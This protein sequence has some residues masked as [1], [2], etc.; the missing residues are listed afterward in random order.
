MKT[1]CYARYSS[2]L[3]RETSLEDQISEAARYATERGWGVN[4]GHIYTD[5]GVSGASIEGR[6]GLQALLTASASTPRPFDVVLVD[7][8][9]RIA[10]DLADALRTMQTLKFRGVRVIYISQGIDSASEQADALVTMH[11]LVDQLYLREMAKKIKRGLAGQFERGFV[12]GGKTYGYRTIGVPSGTINV[13]GNPELVGKRRV[14]HD[15]EADVVRRIFE[16]TARGIGVFTIIR[17]LQDRIPGPW[18]KPWTQGTIRRILRNEVYLGKLIW[19][20][21]SFERQPG[22]NK[23]V[24]RPQPRAQW[25]VAE[26][27]NLRIISDT[28]WQQVRAR[29][30]ET[31]ARLKDGHL[32]RGGLPGSRSKHLL[33]GFL[34]CG[35]CG[36]SVGVVSS[37]K[38]A[39][40]R[41]GCVRACR[42]Y[43]C[44]NRIETKVERL[45]VR[46]LDRLQAELVKP[47]IADY[48]VRETIRRGH[49]QPS[50]RAKPETLTAE[51]DRERQKLQNLVRALEDGEPSATIVQAIRTREERIRTLEGERA[52]MLAPVP[53]VVLE[54][55]RVRQELA[56]LAGLLRES[57]ERARPVFRQLQLQVT[58]FPIEAAGE[59]P[60]LK[61][62]ATCTLDALTT[63]FPIMRRSLE[64]A[65]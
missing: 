41:Y 33:S 36:G 59:R 5:A 53:P 10:R 6:P 18:G 17:R 14:L 56:N 16:W 23:K 37:G 7:D 45:E 8:S 27:P 25:K 2:D 38:A 13:D 44:Q 65:A 20:R 57:V 42:Q 12:T 32:A 55:E 43:T 63:E 58:L 52:R 28:L 22:T 15:A 60:H 50:G 51:I 3:Q 4:P 35:E 46:V 30:H 54:P 49:Q 62:V 21:I 24:R 34:R 26:T 40:P 11:G 39:G 64:R 19:G 31:R 61:A 1:A 47:E 9:S 29:E 48:I